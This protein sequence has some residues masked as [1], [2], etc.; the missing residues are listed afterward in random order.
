MDVYR[1]I[2]AQE[3]IGGIDE[4]RDELRDRFGPPPEQALNLLDLV[5][6]RIRAS[7]RGVAKAELGGKGTLIV[8]FAP[9]RNPSKNALGALAGGFEGRIAF[10]T[11]KG[12]KIRVGPTP[13]GAAGGRGGSPGRARAAASDLEKMLN[14]LEFYAT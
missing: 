1:R 11:L 2:A 10:D 6:L 13:E 3:G 5:S 4:I 9:G 8:E 7:S 12:L 14:L